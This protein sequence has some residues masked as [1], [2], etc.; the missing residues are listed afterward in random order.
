[1]KS[2]ALKASLLAL[3]SAQSELDMYG[4]GCKSQPSVCEETGLTCVMWYDIQEFDRYTCQDCDNTNRKF[5][6]EYNNV[7]EFMCPGEE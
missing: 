2:I 7:L 4:P 5:K 6:D 1:M 3:A